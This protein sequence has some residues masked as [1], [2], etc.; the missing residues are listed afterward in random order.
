MQE[1]LEQMCIAFWS[2][3]IEKRGK[4]LTEETEAVMK[5]FKDQFP[6]APAELAGRLKTRYMI[7]HK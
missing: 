5:V 3:R 4:S 7:S 1:E 6:D 2:I